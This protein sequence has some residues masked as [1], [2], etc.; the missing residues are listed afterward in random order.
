MISEV[1][2]YGDSSPKIIKGEKE[3]EGVTGV[4]SSAIMHTSPAYLL[5]G[6][7]RTKLFTFLDRGLA[8][9]SFVCYPGPI[10]LKTSEPQE[11]QQM[12]FDMKKKATEQI[13]T[14]KNIFLDMYEKTKN[15]HDEELADILDKNL[16]NIYVLD[17][18]A[19]QLINHYQIK[20]QLEAK[21]IVESS[22][23]SG[24][25]SEKANRHWKALK[26]SGLIACFEHP[27]KKQ[28]ALEDVER[29][30]EITDKYGL[31]ITRFYDA[32]P[33]SAIQELFTFFKENNGKWIP[34]MVIYEKGF[35]KK[36]ETKR[37]LDQNLDTVIEMLESSGYEFEEEP[38]GSRGM[39][40]RATYKDITI[41]E[42]G[43]LW[44]ITK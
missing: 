26:L 11:V 31:Q 3:I 41:S 33:T 43:F 27:D 36:N 7:N 35:V 37:F 18:D 10:E 12:I 38:H 29:A 40:Y 6:I 1:F 32:K 39:R 9:R 23:K 14:L 42:E 4:A 22:D 21:N 25:K 34:R 2:D 8:R 24:I 13:P 44:S 19:D 30:I 28:V 16:N 5:E 15:T 17:S 20:N